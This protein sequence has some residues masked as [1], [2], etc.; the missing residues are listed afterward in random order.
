MRYKVLQ[1]DQA[2]ISHCSEQF[3]AA[4]S[5]ARAKL[6][7]RWS[8]DKRRTLQGQEQINHTKIKR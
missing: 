8:F 5:T 2:N 1:S 4:A 3:R 6:Y 7:I